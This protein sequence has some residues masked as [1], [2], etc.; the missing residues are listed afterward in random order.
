M[1]PTRQGAVLTVAAAAA[2]TADSV[3]AA[4]DAAQGAVR[5]A[6]A[7]NAARG[8]MKPTAVDDA[9][10]LCRRACHD[11]RRHGLRD[12]L[13]PRRRAPGRCLGALHLWPGHGCRRHFRPSSWSPRSV[14]GLPPVHQT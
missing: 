11:H 7:D 8:A 2:T 9:D 4:S 5:P 3:A 13:G 12:P 1:V 6:T 10:G 14:P